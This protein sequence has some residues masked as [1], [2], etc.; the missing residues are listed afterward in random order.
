MSVRFDSAKF[1]LA[2]SF[3]LECLYRAAERFP[4]VQTFEQN[5]EEIFGSMYHRRPRPEEAAE[6]M[7]FV[8]DPRE[9]I[10]TPITL[11]NANHGLAMYI[12]INSDDE[13]RT[14]PRVVT[15][16]APYSHDDEET[17]VM[18][19]DENYVLAMAFAVESIASRRSVTLPML[20]NALNTLITADSRIE[21]ILD[22]E[23][24]S[25]R[26]AEKRRSGYGPTLSR[27][28]RS[29]PPRRKNKSHLPR[30]KRQQNVR[31]RRMATIPSP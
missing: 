17:P 24:C 6:L 23:G 11:R 26:R 30:K 29:K 21:H 4:S 28:T 5:I 8:G 9:F 22:C 31:G 19:T 12:A 14:T 15:Q 13:E 10:S 16:S 25:L 1:Y 7:A 20:R 27:M 2:N 3:D 18:A